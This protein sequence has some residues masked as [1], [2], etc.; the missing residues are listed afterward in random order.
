V[1]EEIVVFNR[2]FS[3]QIGYYHDSDLAVGNLPINI[4][5]LLIIRF[6]FILFLASFQVREQV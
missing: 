4:V 3:K 2:V 5:K 1:G 6:Y